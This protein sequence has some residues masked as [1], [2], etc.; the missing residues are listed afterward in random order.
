MINTCDECNNTYIYVQI[1]EHFLVLGK[2]ASATVGLAASGFAKNEAVIAHSQVPLGN[3]FSES[4]GDYGRL[5]LEHHATAQSVLEKNMCWKSGPEK[6]IRSS[7]KV[8]LPDLNILNLP[9][10]TRRGGKEVEVL[11]SNIFLKWHFGHVSLLHCPAAAWNVPMRKTLIEICGDQADQRCGHIMH[12]SRL[13]SCKNDLSPKNRWFIVMHDA[14]GILIPS[15]ITTQ[16][17]NSRDLDNLSK[18]H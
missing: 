5:R 2:L 10:S 1:T 7:Y 8:W 12:F 16:T 18:K 6:P 15:K 14:N 9:E 13:E 11:K 17:S 3:Q 4:R